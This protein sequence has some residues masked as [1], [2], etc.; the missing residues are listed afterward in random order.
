M[1]EDH[2]IP[3]RDNFFK[4]IYSKIAKTFTPFFLHFTPN[5]VT[6]ISGILGVIG[7]IFLISSNYIFIAI[8]SILIQ[9]YTILDLVD[10]NIARQKNLQSKFGMW[11]DIFFDK[12]I[13]F[14]II[15]TS[16]IGIYLKTN[17]E[18]ILILGIFLMGVVFF[19][20]FIMV[21]NDTYFS[22]YKNTSGKLIE[23]LGKNKLLVL[24]TKIVKF[25]IKHLFL[26]HTTFLF[27]ISFFAILNLMHFGIYF[28]TIHGTISLIL[29]ILV[30]FV[31][32]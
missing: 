18:N 27:F 3:K 6:L 8:A 32:L 5:Q 10:G 7:A 17:D 26:Y 31:K 24:V 9:L 1:N 15:F 16:S 28:L 20:Q 13:D 4:F 29:L 30:N 14:L 19:N 22:S 2:K 12:L 25:F 21:L 23:S 11:L